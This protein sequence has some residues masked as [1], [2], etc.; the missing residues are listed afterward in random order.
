MA[1][2]RTALAPAPAPAPQ[3]TASAA[4]LRPFDE[5]DS[6]R[7]QAAL[8][9]RLS[10]DEISTRDGQGGQ[11]VS[12]VEAWRMIDKAQRIFGFDELEDAEEDEWS[13]PADE[14]DVRWQALMDLVPGAG[15]ATII[16]EANK[17]EAVRRGMNQISVP[18]S[19]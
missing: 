6:A 2:I 9:Q 12:Y 18:D 3:P 4:P 13:P 8:E 11:R 17:H 14:D 1:D 10:P 16:P 7:I 19:A 5:A 15:D